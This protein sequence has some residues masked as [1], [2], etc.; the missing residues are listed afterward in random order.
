VLKVIAGGALLTSLALGYVALSSRPAPLPAPRP[1]TP[2][3]PTAPPSAPAPEADSQPATPETQTQLP[4]NT[5]PQARAEAHRAAATAADELQAELALL[6]GAQV[7]WRAQDAAAALALLEQHRTRY[8]RSQLGLERDSLQVLVLC[9]LGRRDEAG[10]LAHAVLARAP[11]SP[12]RA[13]I[14]QSCALK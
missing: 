11:H 14:E 8:P 10:R 3:P 9:E 5:R 4:L 1:I 7:A 2:P 6:H 13:S 12:L